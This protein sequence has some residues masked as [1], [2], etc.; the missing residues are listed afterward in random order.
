MSKE[1]VSSPTFST[2]GEISPG[3]SPEWVTE[4]TSR[5]QVQG[6][7]STHLHPSNQCLILCGHG[8]KR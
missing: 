5:S 1:P 3:Q 8:T 7:P 2:L 4:G 6:Q